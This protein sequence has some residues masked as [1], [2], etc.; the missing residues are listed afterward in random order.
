[1]KKILFSI[2]AFFV[3]LIASC[4]PG[5]DHASAESLLQKET[6]SEEDYSEM[7]RLYDKSVDDAIEY[8][9]EDQDRLS[10]DQIK[11]VMLMFEL[12]SRMSKDYER[13]TDTQREQFE[14]I[15]NKGINSIRK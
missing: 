11:E 12:G 4:S 9:K 2:F 5:F 14:E 10:R 1:M 8:S 7:L 13:L 6:L 3:L 15:N